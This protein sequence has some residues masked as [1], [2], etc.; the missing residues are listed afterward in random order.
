MD[1]SVESLNRIIEAR[2]K[3]ESIRA[4]A[5]RV[6]A[7]VEELEGEML[8]ALENL[9]VSDITIA[10]VTVQVRHTMSASKKADRKEV[11][12]ALYEAGLGEMV[13]ESWNPS[14]VSALFRRGAA[15]DSLLEVFEIHKRRSL[16]VKIPLEHEIWEGAR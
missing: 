3:A 11:V 6:A 9:G 5:D 8:D 4:E 2:R 1:L 13:Y 15:P 12:E 14:S 7:E 10:G 16:K